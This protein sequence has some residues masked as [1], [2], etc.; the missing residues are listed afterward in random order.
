MVAQVG[1]TVIADQL[2]PF[3]CR[4]SRSGS[5]PRCPPDSRLSSSTRPRRFGAWACC[6]WA[7]SSSPSLTCPTARRPTWGSPTSGPPPPFPPFR[8]CHFVHHLP[9]KFEG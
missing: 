5:T 2:P 3:A 1:H 6:P 8:G 9:E 4:E 7:T